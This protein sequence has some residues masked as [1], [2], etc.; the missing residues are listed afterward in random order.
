MLRVFNRQTK[1]EAEITQLTRMSNR[2]NLLEHE[3]ETL[4]AENSGLN[5]IIIKM[6]NQAKE[7]GLL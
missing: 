1:T 7:T 5:Q 3:N 4:V 6:T 2:I